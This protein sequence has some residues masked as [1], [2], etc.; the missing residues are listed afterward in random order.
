M[1]INRYDLKR[2]RDK[3]FQLQFRYV[4]PEDLCERFFHG[5][6]YRAWKQGCGFFRKE[7]NKAKKG[8]TKKITK[9]ANKQRNIQKI[10]K[11]LTVFEKRFSCM[12]LPHAW[13]LFP[14]KKLR[15]SRWILPVVDSGFISY[16]LNS[17]SSK[18]FLK[19]ISQDY[20]QLYGIINYFAT[21]SLIS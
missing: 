16:V 8:H 14:W 20:L 6:F 12:W 9:W 18:T 13:N 3:D 4:C 17:T 10:E 7:P 21:K 19:T 5:I 2:H 11:L 15:E 1:S